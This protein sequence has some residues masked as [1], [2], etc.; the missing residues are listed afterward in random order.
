MVFE[1]LVREYD[2]SDKKLVYIKTQEANR[3]ACI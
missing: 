2:L 3:D 1:Q